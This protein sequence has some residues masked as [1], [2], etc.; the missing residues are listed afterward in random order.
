MKAKKL[1]NNTEKENK[2]SRLQKCVLYVGVHE[3][4]LDIIL[5]GIL[6]F[7]LYYSS[8]LMNKER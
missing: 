2:N 3:C 4:V 5:K 1:K 8:I 7:P 6:L